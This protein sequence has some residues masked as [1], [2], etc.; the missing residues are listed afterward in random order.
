MT[1]QTVDFNI[2]P[3]LRSD[4][5]QWR[6]RALIF[7]AVG[8]VLSAIGFFIDHDQFYRSYL[9]SYIYVVA[10]AVGPLAWLM[11]QFVTGGAWG[12]VI[13]RSC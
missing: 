1:A 9:W 4:M 12:L 11:L 13:R 6:R 5:G 2:T 3:E 10:L 8:A 7:G